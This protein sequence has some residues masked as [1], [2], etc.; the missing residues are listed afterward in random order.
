L[1]ARERVQAAI[2]GAL[3]AVLAA[4]G[5]LF[6]SQYALDVRF[7]EHF[8]FGDLVLPV[9]YTW[10]LFGLLLA[11]DVR[12][13]AYPAYDGEKIAVIIP[14][15]NESPELVEECIG[16]VF[17]AEGRKQVIVIDD[18]STNG[19][20][21]HLLQV[22]S[23]TGATVA[24]FPENRGKREALHLAVTHLL[25]DDVEFVVTIDS[26]TLLER[27]ALVRVVEPLKSP[28]IGAS[29]GNVLLLNERQN[30]LTRMI[31]TYYWIGL[32]VY[33]QAQSVI[34]SVV[35][36]SGC[37]AA[38]RADLL[39]EVIDEFAAQR[40]LGES[41]THSEDRHLTNLVLRRNYDVVYVAEA[42]S[43]TET[44]ATVRGFLRQQRRWKRGYI[45]ESIYTLSYAWRNKK[46]LFLQIL[47]WDLTAPFLSFGLRIGLIITVIH[48][49]LF[50]LTVILP[51]WVVMALVRYVFV[52]LRARDKLFG[53]FL[54]MLFYESCLYWLNIW[55][56]FTVK[57][58]S[59]VT[60]QVAAQA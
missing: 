40:F 30:L 7:W 42:V 15:F 23:G 35:C 32:S 11:H 59:W 3:F 24:L 2:Y 10:Y 31:G 37:L 16:T 9:V 18:G 55:A 29:T 1:T 22:C 17:A 54:Y 36:C 21:D 39:R 13:R 6:L 34:R 57:N 49:P 4:S 43:W 20:Q 19:I 25:D 8:P 56:L 53:L 50:V 44:P 41:C 38:D 48:A 27:D 51:S 60:R 33:K 12:P 14:C 52:P 5:T 45:R 47:L 26:D 28:N 46:L 58:R